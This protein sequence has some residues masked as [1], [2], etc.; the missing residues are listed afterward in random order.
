M[1]T[2]RITSREN[3]FVKEIR[4]LRLKKNRIAEHRFVIEGFKMFHEAV[5]SGNF[6]Y[7][8][9]VSDEVGDKVFPSEII[10]D[11]ERSSCEVYSVPDGLFRSISATESPQG[12]LAVVKMPLSIYYAGMSQPV[13]DD[14]FSEIAVDAASI[15]GGGNNEKVFAVVLE[16]IMDPGN[17]GSIIRTAD[18]FGCTCVV[19]SSDCADIF[20][21][22]TI[23]ATMGSIFHIH[24]IVVDDIAA[25]VKDMKRFGVRI[26]AAVPNSRKSCSSADFTGHIAIIIGNEAHG[27]GSAV[28]SEADELLAIPMSGRAESLNASAASAVLLYEVSRQRAR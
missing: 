9:V 16:G 3:Q 10:S 26:F 22:K 6:P 2:T 13:F 21:D 24:I 5:S 15:E 4:S 17:L 18:A 1:R 7:Y 11:M 19:A 8:A 27:L 12:I 23:R 20:N 14:V 28:L 25:S